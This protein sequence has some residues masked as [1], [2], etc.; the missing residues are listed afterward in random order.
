MASWRAA[1]AL[2]VY[3][4]WPSSALRVSDSDAALSHAGNIEEAL[5]KRSSI[6]KAGSFE[7]SNHGVDFEGGLSLAG[8]QQGNY[9]YSL[10][11]SPFGD[12]L[13][14]DAPHE[15]Q[16]LQQLKFKTDQLDKQLKAHSG[17][18]AAVAQ[19]P[20][21]DIF[22]DATTMEGPLVAE[23]TQIQSLLEQLC[24]KD[25]NGRYKC[26]VKNVQEET[27]LQVIM[28]T[29]AVLATAAGIVAGSAVLGHV[30]ALLT[31]V[32]G[33][34]SSMYNGITTTT[35]DLKLLR[36]ELTN[37]VHHENEKTR[38]V[39]G[40][41][42]SEM[43]AM[44]SKAAI[45]GAS[46]YLELIETGE[47][48]R[49]KHACQMATQMRFTQNIDKALTAFFLT[50]PSRGCAWVVVQVRIRLKNKVFGRF[51]AQKRPKNA[52]QD[53]PKKGQ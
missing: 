25:E 18:A 27:V 47:K 16:V 12:P 53:D 51:F 34:I 21:T 10:A 13:P 41:I 33:G 22:Q 36:N 23:L 15:V 40:V 29:G 45:E 42:L 17:A 6:D 48:Y 24:V 4:S 32:S 11:T 35:G 1:A 19:P 5:V 50:N 9:S 31:A 28:K 49:G 43:Q 7:T 30:A 2:L 52:K 8:L 14:H 20:A 38:Q 26:A 46:T 3:I 39:I 37:V 44:D